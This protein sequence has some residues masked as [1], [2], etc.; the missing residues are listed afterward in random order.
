MTASGRRGTLLSVL[1]PVYNERQTVLEVLERVLRV[2]LELE[3]VVVDDGS[4]DGTRDILRALNDP[5]VQ[6]HFHETNQGKGMAMRTAIAHATGEILAVQ[7]ADLEY[8]P[9]EFVDLVK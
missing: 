4:T 9:E 3:V 5:R 8:R 1:I 7:D 6:V 2:P